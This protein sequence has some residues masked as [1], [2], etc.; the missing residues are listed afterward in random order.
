PGAICAMNWRAWD[1]LFVTIVLGT[2]S[3][4]CCATAHWYGLWWAI[5]SA[6]L[7]LT[8]VQGIASSIPL[9][10]CEVSLST[11]ALSDGRLISTC[12]VK[13]LTL[14]HQPTFARARSTTPREVWTSYF[15]T[16]SFDQESAML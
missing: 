1:G 6:S 13:G 14:R 15:A 2:R 16:A 8:Q 11:N 3:P 4:T 9:T 12:G 7:G 5:E 10:A